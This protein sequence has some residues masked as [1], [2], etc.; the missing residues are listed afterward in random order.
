MAQKFSFT[1]IFLDSDPLPVQTKQWKRRSNRAGR[2]EGAERRRPS[3]LRPER[4]GPPRRRRFVRREAPSGAVPGGSDRLGAPGRRARGPARILERRP[5]PPPHRPSWILVSPQPLEIIQNAEIKISINFQGPR[6]R[7]RGGGARAHEAGDA[8]GRGRGRRRD[9][10]APAAARPRP[11]RFRGG[12][13]RPGPPARAGGKTLLSLFGY[14]GAFRS[15]RGRAAHGIGSMIVGV[16]YASNA[17]FNFLVGLLVARFLGPAEF[18]RFAIAF[19]TAVLVNTGAF[20]WIRVSAVRFYSDREPA[21]APRIARHPRRLF[22]RARASG[23]PRRGRRRLRRPRAA[24]VPRAG[25]DGRRGGGGERLLRLSH[26]AR[27]RAL[28]RPRLRAHDHRQELPRPRADGR[29]RL[30]VRLGADRARRHLPQRRRGAGG[31]RGAPCAIPGPRR[32]ARSARSPA[33]SCA[34][35]CR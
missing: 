33:S 11:S 6:R 10:R 16:A 24:A 5:V 3:R 35:A 14:Q 28:P 15:A 21:G 8:R 31:P 20:D 12:T 1:E 13:A 18:G 32:G 34:T 30:V 17:L 19:A 29:R 7:A 4:P 22:R 25:R 2:S 9:G 26:R 27:P 23:E